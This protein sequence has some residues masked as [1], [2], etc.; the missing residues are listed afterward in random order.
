[1]SA[2]SHFA[3]TVI[4][5]RLNW[6]LAVPRRLH[7][8]PC[9]C[10]RPAPLLRL[11]CCGFEI[12]LCTRRAHRTL[13]SFHRSNGFIVLAHHSACEGG[14]VEKIDLGRSDCNAPGLIRLKDEPRVS[15]RSNAVLSAKFAIPIQVGRSV[16]QAKH[17]R[18]F[19]QAQAEL[20]PRHECITGRKLGAF[21]TRQANLNRS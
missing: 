4:E 14:R 6:S 13:D 7:R 20:R 11:S 1:M 15:S 3:R 8:I 2:L 21:S 17:G 16:R 19:C 10:P 5:L 9:N 18:E 12:G